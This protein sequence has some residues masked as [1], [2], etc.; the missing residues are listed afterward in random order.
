[1]TAANFKNCCRYVPEASLR[2]ITTRWKGLRWAMPSK[3]FIAPL[4]MKN[5]SN[6][7]LTHTHTHTHAHGN[8]LKYTYVVKKRNK[9]SN[10]DLQIAF[11]NALGGSG[12]GGAL[13]SPGIC[14]P[15]CFVRCPFWHSIVST[16]SMVS[17]KDIRCECTREG[18]Q[19]LD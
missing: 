17:N 8:V 18:Q 1:M 16:H 7:S 5:N 4:L 13:T 12:G 2:N 19:N 14:L 6:E 15:L 10:Q 9:K 3:V 11:G